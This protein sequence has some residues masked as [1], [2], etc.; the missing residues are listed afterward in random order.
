MITT[1]SQSLNT[2]HMA[3]NVSIIGGDSETRLIEDQLLAT[4]CN[5]GFQIPTINR[6]ANISQFQKRLS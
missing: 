3:Q 1:N 6:P 2:K 4:A 5:F